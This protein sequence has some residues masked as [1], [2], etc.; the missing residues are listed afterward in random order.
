[1]KYDEFVGRVQQQTNLESQEKS[2][3]AIY[4]TLE[5]LGECLEGNTT[6]HLSS[7]LSPV[8][9]HYLQASDN[10]EQFTVDEFFQR[11]AEREDVDLP[12][13]TH[14]AQVVISVLVET[15]NP[16][17]LAEALA[18]LPYLFKLLFEA[19]TEGENPRD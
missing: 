15:I 8:I 18:Q 16:E 1:M 3:R 11:V 13:A 19:D 7:H 5:T 14:H 9:G 17:E 12:E 10:N 6:D 2:V 4:A